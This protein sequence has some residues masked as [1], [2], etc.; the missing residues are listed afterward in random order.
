MHCVPSL[1]SWPKAEWAALIFL[2]FPGSKSDRLHKELAYKKMCFVNALRT[3][4]EIFNSV[5]IIKKVFRDT[6]DGCNISI[7]DKKMDGKWDKRGEF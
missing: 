5:N 1:L 3:Q 4:P 6:L 2:Q 7:K